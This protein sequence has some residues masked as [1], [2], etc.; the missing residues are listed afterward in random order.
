MQNGKFGKL[1]NMKLFGNIY[2]GK[3]VVVT[4]HTGFKGSWLVFWLQ[5][6]G[7][8]VYGIS[9]KI[10]TNPSH[11]ELLQ[12]NIDESFIDIINY[13][14]LSNKLQEIQ[15]DI[16][17]HLAAQALVRYSYQE[18]IETFTTN[19]IGTANIFDI[20]RSLASIKGIINVT[21]D[22]CYENFE[23]DWAY[24]ES[25]R[26]GGYD[27]YSASKGAAELIVSSYRRSFFNIDSFGNSHHFILASGRAGNVIGG[28]DW[29]K[30]RLI[31]DLIKNSIAN[32]TTEIRNP[33]A[34]R[35]WQH[36]LEPLSGYLLLGQKVLEGDIS[37]SDGWNFGPKK[38]EV[39]TVQKVLEESSLVWENLKFHFPKLENQPHEAH[40]LRLDCSKANINL[41]W[42]PVWDMNQSIKKTINW[43]KDFYTINKI[44]TEDDLNTYVK[45]AIEKQ[46]IWTK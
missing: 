17:F 43:Y 41:N 30:D 15:P 5:K 34:T 9:D 45:D 21:S 39:L 1:Y 36:V 7:A 33:S 2:Q 10:Y 8:I 18:P 16:I 32:K 25:D 27:P 37:V 6:L 4:G 24:N 22:K 40:F 23:N 13:K 12:L 42:Y 19:I 11:I 26:M 44:N 31:P 35:P 29:S 20:C 28:G 3:K 14:E 38:S 46:I